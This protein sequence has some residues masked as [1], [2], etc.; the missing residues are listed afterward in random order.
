MRR[1]LATLAVLALAGPSPALAQ[2]T[3]TNAPPGNSA[4][5]EY[6]ESVPSAGGN[7]PTAAIV[8]DRSQTLGGRAGRSLRASGADGRR[9][10]QIVAATAPRKA[11]EAGNG[12]TT[13]APSA[14][15]A[16]GRSPLGSV[17]DAVLKGSGGGSGM[18]AVFP[19]LLIGLAAATVVLGLRRRRATP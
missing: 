4:I 2:S 12:G 14:D 13:A 11:I 1:L 5:D 16:K 18:G 8:H 17:A 3:Q 10:A 7:T 9:L 6:L 15:T 19:I